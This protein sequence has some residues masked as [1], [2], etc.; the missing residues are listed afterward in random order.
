M[1]IADINV[2]IYNSK[3][4]LVSLKEEDLNSEEKYNVTI[5]DISNVTNTPK[6]VIET[7][8]ADISS[9][10][11]VTLSNDHFSVYVVILI[12]VNLEDVI[13]WCHEKR[14]VEDRILSNC[15]IN[16]KEASAYLAGYLAD[17]FVNILKRN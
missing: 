5:N 12:N 2:D 13:Q 10:H 3:I 7:A 1:Q 17:K 6:C 4:Y 9:C 15:N 14:H 16:D 11:A 8:I